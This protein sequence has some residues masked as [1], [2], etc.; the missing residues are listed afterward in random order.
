[1]VLLR[2]FVDLLIE[3]DHRRANEMILGAATSGV[4]LPDI[5]VRILQP[6]MQEIGRRCE[7]GEAT[8]VDEQFAESVTRRIMARLHADAARGAARGR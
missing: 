4:T 3:S 8:E 1:M 6:A 5:D 2:C 7:G